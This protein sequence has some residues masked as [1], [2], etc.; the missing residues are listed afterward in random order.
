LTLR[1]LIA[2]ALALAGLS[3]AACSTVSA[4]SPGAASA[5]KAPTS[6]CDPVEFPIYFQTGSDS[7]TPPAV[8][9]IRATAQRTKACKVAKV[10][11]L[12]LADADGSAARNLQLSQ[13]RAQ[14]VAAALAA[15]G[16]PG[17]TF[18]LEAGGAAGATNARGAADPV[19]RRTEVHVSFGQ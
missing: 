1:L 14:K 15:E 6:R 13:Q 19:R 8:E 17:A 18:D 7:L 4:P 10:E 11:V 5:M 2:P 12:G 3:L 9:M 16:F